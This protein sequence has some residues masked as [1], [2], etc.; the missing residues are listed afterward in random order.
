MP[1]ATSESLP[2]SHGG[3]EPGR[4]SHRNASGQRRSLSG[5]SQKDG[6]LQAADPGSVVGLCPAVCLPGTWIWSGGLEQA[7]LTDSIALTEQMGKPSPEGQEASFW[8]SWDQDL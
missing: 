3:N 6:W 5:G 8:K 2:V 1:A 7:Q 4:V